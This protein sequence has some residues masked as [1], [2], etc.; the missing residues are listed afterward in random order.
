M[1][2]ACLEAPHDVCLYEILRVH[3]SHPA[4]APCRAVQA[5]QALIFRQPEGACTQKIV[6]LV[7]LSHEGTAWQLQ[8]ALPSEVT[9]ISGRVSRLGRKG[10][11]VA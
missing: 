7:V 1:E 11:T 5:P 9:Q 6:V 10:Q 3:W 2:R 4:A 8:P